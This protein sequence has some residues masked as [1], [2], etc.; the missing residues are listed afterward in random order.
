MS[1]HHSGAVAAG[2]PLTAAA[3]RF[4]LESGGNAFDAVLAAHYAA[5]VVEPILSSLGGG[6]FLLARPL[7]GEPRVYDFFVQTP[8]QKQPRE[9][10][11]FYPIHAD[12]GTTRQEFHIGMA[13]IAT[14]GT[15]KGI[16]RIHRELASLPMETLLQPAIRYAREG[17][18]ITPL[19]AY[20]FRVIAPI[21]YS[22]AAARSI[23]QSHASAEA[24]LTEGEIHYQPELADTLEQLGREGERFFYEGPIARRIHEDSREAG[25][26]LG[27]EDL[28]HYQVAVRRPVRVSYRDATLYTNPPPSSGG[29]LIAFALKL[30]EPLDIQGMGRDSV[31]YLSCL[32][33]AMEQTNA[34]RR[35]ATPEWLRQTQS[36]RSLLAGGFLEKYQQVLRSHPLCSRGTTHISVLDQQGNL[37]SLTTSNGEGSG[38]VVPGTGI[39][40]NNMLGEEDI[41]PAGF[42]QWPVDTRIS[43]M[44]APSLLLQPERVVVL[45]SGGSNRIRSAIL[46]TLV[47]LV[48]FA[49]ELEAAIQQPRLHYEEGILNLEHDLTTQVLEPLQQR[50]AQVRAWPDRN[51]FFGGVHAV[52]SDPSYSVFSGAGD[53]RRGGVAT[54]V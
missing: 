47:S 38:Y 32:A 26:H 33:L 28:R 46:Q 19:Q 35:E 27:L 36:A 13:S 22:S 1:T 7:G 8:R 39:M 18:P 34:A 53:P 42:H 17:V 24:L 45:G 23:Y 52:A 21:L 51:L 25:G 20:L 16:F 5:C 2:H 4:A 3:A 43:S 41:N 37:A 54:I 6:G 10:R 48:D 12:F 30:L 49:Q 14:P 11:D 29:L 31:A 15:V 9:H 44:M 40:L 50:F